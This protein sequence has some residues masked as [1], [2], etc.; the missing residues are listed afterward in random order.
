MTT[1]QIAYLAWRFYGED[2]SD[3]AIGSLVWKFKQGDAKC[4]RYLLD[5]LTIDSGVIHREIREYVKK[6]LIKH[7]R[8]NSTLSKGTLAELVRKRKKPFWM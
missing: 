5:I 3:H 4:K 8:P 1:D 6:A 2:I 7:S